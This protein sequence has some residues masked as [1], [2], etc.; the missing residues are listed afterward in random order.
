MACCPAHNDDGP[1]LSIREMDDGR[2]LLHDFGGCDTEAI[3]EAIGLT[4][5]D[6]FDAPL[7]HHLK[8]IRGGFSARELIEFNAQE[9]LVAL[10]LATTASKR[11]LTEEETERLAKAAS[12]LLEAY[13]LANG[14][15]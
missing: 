14:K 15:N 11:A 2:V 3:M 6:L 8:P 5:G 10:E 7:A 13:T 1:S 4:L 12:R 9:T